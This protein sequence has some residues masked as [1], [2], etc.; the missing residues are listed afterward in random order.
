MKHKINILL[1]ILLFVFGVLFWNYA[2]HRPAEGFSN[3]VFGILGL[4]ITVLGS[5]CT[6]SSVVYFAVKRSLFELKNYNHPFILRRMF[7]FFFYCLLSVLLFS[8]LGIIALFTLEVL[9]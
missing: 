7:S 1:S 8:L 2:T 9:A 4:A 5:I 3:L 6:V